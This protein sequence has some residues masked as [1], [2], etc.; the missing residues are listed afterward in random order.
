MKLFLL[1]HQLVIQVYGICIKK[2]FLISKK[3]EI[4]FVDILF[5]A[6]A[7]YISINYFYLN[8]S[9]S[10]HCWLSLLMVPLYVMVRMVAG[11]EKHRRW[12]IV[13]ILAAVLA[14]AVLGL[15]QLYGFMHSYHNLYRITG[16]FSNPGPYAGFLAVGAPLALGVS[17]DK[18]LFRWERWLGVGALLACLLVLPATMS[19][20]AWIAA[21][22]GCFPVI[23]GWIKVSRLNFK[24]SGSKLASSVAG[25]ITIITVIIVLIL[26][27]FAGIYLLKKDSADGR[28]V[29]WSVS[30]ELV[31]EHPL[32]GAGYGRFAAVYGDAQATYFLEKE[33]PANQMMV[34]DSPEYAFNEY[35]QIAVEL[36]I[37][38][39]ALFLLLI[40]SCFTNP[41]TLTTN[42]Y[43]LITILVFAAFSYPFSVLPLCI[44][45]VFLL[46]LS[47]PSSR[48]LPFTVPV[49]M[50]VIG[51]A[52]CWGITAYSAYQI[53]PKR[54]AYR[55][56]SSLRILYNVSANNVVAKEYA[57]L[58][59]KLQH[60]KQFLFEY[61]QCLSKM[62]QY[63]ESNRIFEE[64]LRYGSD[65][66]VYNCMGNNFKAMGEY[67]QAESMYIR[68]SQIVPNRHYPLYLLMKLYQEME[69]AGKKGEAEEMEEKGEAGKKAKAMAEILL[70]KPVKV[71][72]TA[73]R[74]MH[75]E[76]RKVINE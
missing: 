49:W 28:R 50:K 32:F 47:A 71:P 7:V 60:E 55:E 74:E 38:G 33:R 22:V 4:R 56:W 64:Y 51:V 29:I 61:G 18:T 37:V 65:P 21:A 44:V 27:S 67:A 35:V 3:N 25:R 40:G 12:F 39:L 62:E 72:S 58:Y 45:F 53:L 41:R 34:A 73:I 59:P 57:A 48:K 23:W 24:I 63:A 46:A 75:E 2:Q 70:Q 19:R 10:I 36:G 26:F 30:M 76:A 1:V 66:M 42:H 9:P 69:E 68:A 54:V 16:T 14:Q 11:N 8:G 20:A 43:A 6:L 52:L 13:A 31:K 17:F 5:I 15:L